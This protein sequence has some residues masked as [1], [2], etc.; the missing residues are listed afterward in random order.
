MRLTLFPRTASTLEYVR[1]TDSLLKLVG[2]CV[3]AG[4]LV[5]GMLFPVVGGL[6][7]LSNRATKTIEE[8]STQLARIPP[9]L[10]TVMLDDEGNRLAT[11][12]K[13]YRIPIS[14]SDISPAM[15]WAMISVE[16]R[17]FYEHNGVDMRGIMRAVV[18][19]S[20][21]GDLQG[22]STITQQYVK[23]Y[24]INVVHRNNEEGQR[25]AQAPTI[26]R[27]MREARLAVE[28]ETRM[29]KQE[30]LAG[31]LNVVE[32]SRQ[33]YGIGAAAQ[34][35]FG[36]TS[37]R[38]NVTQG[39]LLAGMVNN[40]TLYDPWSNPKKA[41]KRRNFVLTKMVQN[42]KLSKQDA[43]RL[44]KEPLGV[45]PEPQVP[46][47]NCVSAGAEN[48]FFCKYV[49]NFL[50]SHGMTREQ[51]LTG[52]YTIKTTMN[53]EA[54]HEAKVSAEKQVSQ[55]EPNV[56]NT[57][58]FVRPGQKRHEVVALAANR[59]FG[60]NPKTGQTMLPLPSDIVNTTGIGSAFKIFTAA[61]TLKQSV[62]GIYDTIP[63]PSSHSSNVYVSNRPDCP[64]IDQY[65]TRAYCLT[66]AHDDYPP[67][68]SLQTALQTSPNTAFVILEEKAG[69]KSVVQ[70]AKKLG[71]RTTM[72]NNLNGNPPK[73]E[74][75]DPELN[76]S[77]LEFFGPTPN[78]DPHGRGSFTLG[79]SPVSGLEMANVAATLMSGGK[80]CPVTPIEKIVDRDGQS[81][82]IKLPSCQ[83]VVPKGLA[84]TLVV[85]MSKDHKE[86][87]T[88][89]A[90]ADKFN[91][92]RP[93]L[94]KT[95]TTERNASAAF[96]GATPQLAGVAMVFQP[97]TPSQGIRYF[98]P[99]NV[100]SVP[101]EQGD[102]F[103][104]LTPAQTWFG[105]MKK[106]MEGKKVIPLPPSAPKYEHMDG[107]GE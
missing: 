46:G 67:E 73:P 40:P 62:A 80:W 54:T 94:G 17:R 2:L 20:V 99:G 51:L 50:T 63:S 44:K 19:N 41:L 5:A 101:P 35:Y 52:G 77:Q 15:E 11:L 37:D 49:M 88:A 36:T 106:I 38:L 105:A 27:K 48:G 59:D 1:K 18:N 100:E 68:M 33:V 31:Y 16:D 9:P 57:L 24:L 92:S 98:G 75:D 8:T 7:M 86:G 102:M 13:Q 60:P 71:L 96:V 87:G 103:G 42:D 21:S 97:E 22:A 84:N 91:W 69:M 3:L 30:I 34:A 61:A 4:V 93:M 28:L 82:P 65:G 89:S 72:S 43:K 64:V 74:S 45:L 55:T 78:R 66:N 56:A 26:A 23:N 90:A 6:G 32:F 29:S 85:G 12:Y 47:S 70:M 76:Q 83:Q 58:S 39:A 10:M 95:G 107:E 79:V 53:Q 81:V 104:G 25:R 14:Y